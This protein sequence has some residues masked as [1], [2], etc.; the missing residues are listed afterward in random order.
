MHSRNVCLLTELAPSK[1]LPPLLYAKP[2]AKAPTPKIM[3]HST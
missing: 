2:T 1:K 3:H